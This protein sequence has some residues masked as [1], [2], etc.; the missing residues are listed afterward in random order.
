MMRDPADFYYGVLWNKLYR[1][2][3]IEEHQLEMD[4][5]LRWCEDFLFNL[6][7][8]RHAERFTAI[9]IP[10]YY[11]MKRKGSLV[12]T[13]W[14]K[15]N[16]V[17]LKFQLLKT[18]KELYQSMDLYEENKLQINAFVLAIAKDGGS[19]RTY[20]QAAPEAGFQGLYRG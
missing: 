6:S 12:S 8:I 14:K 11:Y 15:A 2:R 17:K 10:I 4:R 20:E 16:A 13:D 19:G 5:D 1:R 18:Y 7:F 9:Q 3:I